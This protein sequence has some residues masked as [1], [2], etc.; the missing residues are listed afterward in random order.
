MKLFVLTHQLLLWFCLCGSFAEGLIGKVNIVP[1]EISKAHDCSDIKYIL[2]ETPSGIYTITLPDSE[3]SLQV[4]CDMTT[5]GGGWTV[6][7]RRIDGSEN[8][9]RNWTSYASGFGQLAGE[10]WMGNDNLA[11]LTSKKQYV[12]RVELGDWAGYYRYAQYTDFNVG[13]ASTKYNLTSLGVYS[14][15]AGDSLAH[16]LGKMFSTY[17]Q[18]NDQFRANCSHSCLGAWWYHYCHYSNLNGEYNNTVETGVAS[19]AGVVWRHWHHYY[20]S[21]KFSE[22]KI[23]PA[24]FK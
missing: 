9:F 3:Q 23:R 13:V 18:D 1:K 8:F 19:G 20:Y 2:P 24:N 22:M 21:M 6:F 11:A 12:L 7:Q 15:D 10:F 4:Y 16:H 14:G 5:T 17:D